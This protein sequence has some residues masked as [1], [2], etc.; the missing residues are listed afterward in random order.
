MNG[1]W[2]LDGLKKNRMEWNWIDL[3]LKF[4]IKMNIRNRIHLILNCRR[5]QIVLLIYNQD[6]LNIMLI[7]KDDGFGR[8]WSN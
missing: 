2:E 6:L 1:K 3:K 5:N 8:E 4:L 7:E